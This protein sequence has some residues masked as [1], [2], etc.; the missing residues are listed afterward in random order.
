MTAHEPLNRTC[1]CP[2]YCPECHE[3]TPDDLDAVASWSYATHAAQY[4]QQERERAEMAAKFANWQ[5]G[6]GYTL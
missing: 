5:L 6:K 2:D 1:G 3:P 4:G